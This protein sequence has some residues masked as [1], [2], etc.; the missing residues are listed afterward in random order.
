MKKASALLA[1]AFLSAFNSQLST[2]HAQGTAL[3]YQGRLNDAGVPAGGNYDSAISIDIRRGDQW[4]CPS[5]PA[6]QRSHRSE[7]GLFTVTLDFGAV[8]SPGNR[9]LEIGVRTNG[10][11]GAYTV[12]SPRQALTA[13]PYAIY[14]ANANSAVTAANVTGAVSASQITGTLAASNI[15]AGT[16]ASS[17]LAAGVAAAK[18]HRQR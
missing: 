13:S 8:C 7:N 18:F 3:T 16:I 9:W 11:V 1:L 4:D 12:L 2:A 17:N 14:A 6:H 10:S 15:G 5:W